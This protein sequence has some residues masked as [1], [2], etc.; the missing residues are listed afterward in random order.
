MNTPRTR[1]FHIAALFSVVLSLAEILFA[2]HTGLFLHVWWDEHAESGNTPRPTKPLRLIHSHSSARETGNDP[3][4]QRDSVSAITEV[5]V[6]TP[7]DREE[8]MAQWQ[9]KNKELWFGMDPGMRT[10]TRAR[11]LSP[12]P[13]WAALGVVYTVEKAISDCLDYYGIPSEIDYE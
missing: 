9:I 8:A 5:N 13:V 3:I 10:C 12:D 6:S 4:T 1:P 2:P 7:I 11:Y